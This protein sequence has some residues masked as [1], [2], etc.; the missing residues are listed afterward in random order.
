M[1]DDK[2]VKDLLMDALTYFVIAEN[3]EIILLPAIIWGKCTHI[4]LH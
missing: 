4:L 1:I 3:A 2:K